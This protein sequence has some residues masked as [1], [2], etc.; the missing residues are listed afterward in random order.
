MPQMLATKLTQVIYS[1][2]RIPGILAH[3]ESLWCP[4]HAFDPDEEPSPPCLRSSRCAPVD[5]P[6]HV[7]QC[8]WYHDVNMQA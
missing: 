5:H 3:A 4:M 8:Q 6:C 2:V 1:S 7:M